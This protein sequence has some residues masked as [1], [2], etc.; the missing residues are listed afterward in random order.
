[1]EERDHETRSVCD[2]RMLETAQISPSG[3]QKGIWPCQHFNLPVEL[4]VGLPTCRSVREQICV[5]EVTTFVVI[6]HSSDRKQMHCPL[7]LL[8][9]LGNVDM[10]DS[11]ATWP[12]LCQ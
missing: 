8:L 3:P 2:H 11:P 4:S 10:Q 7:G 9:G 5:V 6:Y 1:M 12:G